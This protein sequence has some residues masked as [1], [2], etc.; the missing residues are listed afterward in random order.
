MDSALAD[1]ANEI[2][3]SMP[4]TQA[5]EQLMASASALIRTTDMK[6]IQEAQACLD[7][8]LAVKA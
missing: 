7:A 8:A 1:K 5:K 4:L 2:L 6:K 3:Y